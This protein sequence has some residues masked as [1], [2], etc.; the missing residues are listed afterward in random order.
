MGAAL[1]ENLAG[2]GIEVVIFDRDIEKL[3]SAAIEGSSRIMAAETITQLVNA[4]ERP[5]KVI[6]LVEAKAGLNLADRDN[7]DAVVGEIAPL[8]ETGDLLIDGGN[9]Y[10]RHTE[11]RGDEL[12]N[13]GIIYTGTGISGGAEGARTG[14]A[15]MPGGPSKGWDM[16]KP[17]LESIAARKND[18]PC[19]AHIG[20]RGAGHY[21]KMLHNSL[22]YCDMQ[23]ICESYQLLKCAGYNNEECAEIFDHWNDGSLESYL[24]EITIKILVTCDE[25]SE[26]PLVDLILD[27]AGQKGTGVWTLMNA[28]ENGVAVPTVAA[29]V[30]AR[31]LSAIKEQR[32]RAAE[33]LSGPDARI[34]VS[35]S[36]LVQMIGSAL[37]AS[38]IASYAQGFELL[39]TVSELLE[40]RWNLDFGSITKL[41]RAGCIIRASF[42]DCVNEAY[43]R[44]PGTVNLMLDQQLGD[45]L[46]RSQAPWRKLIEMA[47]ANGISIP[48]FSA[49]LQ[50]YDGYRASQ[51][52]ANL[53][54]AQRDYF[55]QHGFE[56]ND[57]PLKMNEGGKEILYHGNWAR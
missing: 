51:C 8:L 23:L 48:A 53:L 38:K 35:K 32:V 56:R 20:P 54:Q 25:G 14:P 50:Y 33:H 29:A 13:R 43:E 37:Y 57:R 46:R 47:V 39:R 34:G 28:T 7:V 27:K 9:T 15:L 49:S 17:I 45:V 1:A 16:I 44:N 4:L 52:P 22:E 21:L 6:M 19:V 41:W 3:R 24:I 40:N 36:E 18:V 5:R 42:L 30:Q 31:G 26:R 10:Y 55:G 12:R 11:R 2:H